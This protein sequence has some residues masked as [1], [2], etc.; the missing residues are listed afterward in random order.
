MQIQKTGPTQ[1]NRIGSTSRKGPTIV[2]GRSTPTY[3]HN[4]SRN[5]QATPK[6][7]L[8]ADLRIPHVQGQMQIRGNQ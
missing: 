3:S 1:W 8:G 5:T 2:Q 4:S 7:N 6:R